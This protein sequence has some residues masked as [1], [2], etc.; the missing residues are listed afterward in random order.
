VD[1][2]AL[3]SDG[4]RNIDQ[5]ERA[6]S[7]FRFGSLLFPRAER[8]WALEGAI[9]A[10]LIVGREVVASSPSADG[11]EIKLRDQRSGRRARRKG[12][13]RAAPFP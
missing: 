10:A 3:A 5:R 9:G 7:I 6:A 12:A 1:P 13:A 11:R 8:I 4:L 2:L